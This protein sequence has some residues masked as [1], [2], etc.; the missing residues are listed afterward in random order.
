MSRHTKALLALGLAAAAAVV[1][2]N[3]GITGFAVW[4]LLPVPIALLPLLVEVS[5]A[6][7][8]IAIRVFGYTIL[9]LLLMV[10]SMYLLRMG[11]IF[12]LPPS[13]K[14]AGL[15]FYAVVAG[16]AAGMICTAAVMG[17]ERRSSRGADEILGGRKTGHGR[18]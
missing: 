16:Y 17:R 15:P 6:E 7:I 13:G 5:S 3:G 12:G 9:T 14:L 8:K 2:A 11:G 1:A 4:N 18:S 10:H